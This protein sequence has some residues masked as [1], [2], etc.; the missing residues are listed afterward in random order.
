MLVITALNLTT[1]AVDGPL[2]YDRIP[3]NRKFK[4]S[5][6]APFATNM[7]FQCLSY[8]RRSFSSDSIV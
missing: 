1:L 6:L 8:G 4:V 7:Q 3:L 2:P 5:E